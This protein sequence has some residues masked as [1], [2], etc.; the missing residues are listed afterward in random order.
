MGKFE[1]SV[2][3]IFEDKEIKAPSSVWIGVENGLNADFV[4]SYHSQ[5]SRNQWTTAAAILI[6]VLSLAFQFN[7]IY[8]EEGTLAE[9]TYSGKTYNALVES[10]GVWYSPNASWKNI[11]SFQTLPN[12]VV[13]VERVIVTSEEL[14]LIHI[15]EPTRLRRSS[16]AV[17][18][19]KKKK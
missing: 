3:K 2:R 5:H 19:L 9:G 1:D 15:S 7:P 8:E 4:H 11:P 17:F 12:R 14:S 18:C 16:Y 6:S 13:V 10:Q